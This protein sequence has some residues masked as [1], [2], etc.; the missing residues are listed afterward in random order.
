V[1]PKRVRIGPEI[2]DIEFRTTAS[3][4]MLNDGSYGYTLDLGNLI[5]ISKD[6]SLSKQRVTLMHEI[7]H[8]ARMVFEGTP[9]KKNAEYEEWEHYFI[10]VYE[11]TI[12]MIMSDNK[13]LMEWFNED[14]N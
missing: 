5:V 10:G 1:T 6:I 4:G 2:F 14:N 9:P 13:E 12:L 3:D 11:T 8:A 7:L